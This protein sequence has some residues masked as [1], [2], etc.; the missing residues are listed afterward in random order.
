MHTETDFLALLKE[1]QDLLETPERASTDDLHSKV[2][3]LFVYLD[4]MPE[5]GA[6]LVDA[7]NVLADRCKQLGVRGIKRYRPKEK[8]SPYEKEEL[9]QRESTE[10]QAESEKLAQSILEHSKTLKKKTEA[11]GNMVD[12]SKNLLDTVTTGVR[13]NVHYVEKGV[14]T[15]TKKEWYSFSTTQT[16]GIVLLVLLV[17]CAMYLFIR[18]V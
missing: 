7:Y 9:R 16:I 8:K 2:L 13:K 10:I 18:M 12:L 11:F 15:L 17:F 6:Q 1:T 3:G 4:R 14:D 5:P